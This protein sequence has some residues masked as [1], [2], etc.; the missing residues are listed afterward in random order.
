MPSVSIVVPTYKEAENL[1]ALCE[2]VDEEL[3]KEEV[4]YELLIVGDRSLDDTVNIANALS[5]KFP[6]RL[7]QPQVRDRD[8]SLSVLD[9]IREAIAD[10][11]VVMDADLSHL[12]PKIPNLIAGLDEETFVAGSRYAKGGEFSRGRSFWRFLNSLLV[13][14]M[15]LP[16]TSCGDPMTGFFAVRKQDLKDLN[17]FRPI[18]YKIALELMVRGEFEKIV[19]VPIELKDKVVG[20]SKMNFQQQIN[21]L[22]HLRRLYLCKF[23]SWAEFIHYGTIGATGFVV[24]LS[25]Y[26]LLQLFGIDHRAA[27]A[28]SFW[29]A[30]SWN[31]ALNRITTFGERERRPRTR[32]WLEFVITSI[33]GFSLNWGIYVT[34]TSSSEF[35]NQY[36]I[37]AFMSGIFGAS[38]FNFTASTLFVYSEKRGS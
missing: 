33:I 16:L 21:Y 18:G 25:C 19:E 36:R 29:P 13:K 3:S 27:R 35:F 7:I 24:D 30:V 14:L 22:R 26:Y 5:A 32:Q 4:T 11:V 20:K 9:G 10:T 17:R 2:T 28:I 34:L 23:R 6:L 38:I 37:L 31:W 1:Q 12:I 15:V 8:F